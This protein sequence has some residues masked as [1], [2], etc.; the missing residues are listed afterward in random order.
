MEHVPSY[1]DTSIHGLFESQVEKTPDNTALIDGDQKLTYRELNVRANQLAS[2]MRRMGVTLEDRIAICM[3][4]SVEIVEAL[5]AIVKTGA[6]YVPIDRAWPETR[7]VQVL[8]DS[9]AV[10]LLT[11]EESDDTALTKRPIKTFSVDA[12][13]ALLAKESGENIRRRTNPNELL[14]VVYTSG[15]TGRPKG[16]LVTTGSV[17]NQF[18][19]M[20]TM[21]P[22]RLGDVALLH[23]P[24][25]VIGFPRDSL[26]PLLKGVPVVIATAVEGRDPATLVRLGAEHNISH[27]SASAAL[28]EGILEHAERRQEWRTLRI[29]RTGGDPLG[30]A[31]V[32]RWYRVFPH[33][34]LLNI[35]GATECSWATTCDTRTAQM[36]SCAPAGT[37]LS[38][39]DVQ[40]L[41]NQLQPV[42]AGELGEIYV[43]G[44][45]LAR[46]YLNSPA[47]TAERFI[48]NPHAA[49]GGARLFRTGD[50]G[51]RRADG[52]LE[53][54]GRA[55]LQVKIRGFRVEIEEIEMVLH[56]C[57]GI[58]SAV[59]VSTNLGADV[60]LTAFV[61][62]HRDL[63]TPGRLRAELVKRL[64]NYMVPT[65]F[66]FLT[67]MPQ[68][69]TGKIDRVALAQTGSRQTFSSR[70]GAPSESSTEKRIV[71]IW[72]DVLMLTKVSI[73]ED[74]FEL[75]GHSL[76][77]IQVISRVYDEFGIEVS[78]RT[79]FDSPTIRA[80]AT[81]VE[82]AID[83]ASEA[84]VT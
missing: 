43:G 51:L 83:A 73:D 26:S 38:N 55:D 41:D 21:C 18:A 63:V 9:G 22:Y 16:V 11:R 35:Y 1:E 27:I 74:F 29:G 3:E 54:K 49:D 42:K 14:G 66:V 34:Q 65:E 79:L 77:A 36:D 81:S 84:S 59:V 28:W 20:S 23:R 76:S 80:F 39:I 68:T 56:A 44:S 71:Q 31:T 45:C 33:A 2:Q 64:P 12:S 37:P 52:L 46:G 17:V 7:R 60:R 78:L 40:I 61:V 72:M 58:Q 62:A 13:R 53:I 5:L 57:E 8:E 67:E 4:R 82:L 32:K 47:L 70:A 10:L 48:A 24:Y 25:T 30:A 19:S 69:S 50:I 6:A 75:G 15:S